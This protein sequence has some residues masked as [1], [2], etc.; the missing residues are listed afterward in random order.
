MKQAFYIDTHKGITGVVVA[1]LMMWFG[2][3][4]SVTAWIYLALHGT[5]G[6][7]WVWKSRSSPTANGSSA[8]HCGSASPSGEG[9]QRI[10]WHRGW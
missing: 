4:A 6:L 8:H 1:A 2:R 3:E 5:Y 10:G 9:C 7:L